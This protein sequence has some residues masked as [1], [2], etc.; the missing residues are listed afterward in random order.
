MAKKPAIQMTNG[1]DDIIKGGISI[2]RNVI[3]R[4][5]K[6]ETKF[7]TRNMKSSVSQITKKEFKQTAAYREMTK[8]A[9]KARIK[10]K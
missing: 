2:G 10:K 9:A 4:V 5:S 6:A 8:K 3:K 1:I 7:L